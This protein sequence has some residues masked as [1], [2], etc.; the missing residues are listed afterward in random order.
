MACLRRILSSLYC[1]FNGR[2]GPSE[3]HRFQGLPVAILSHLPFDLRGFLACWNAPISEE[4]A[5]QY[6]VK[7]IGGMWARNWKE[8]NNRVDISLKVLII[9]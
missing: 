1:L 9:F 8:R 6:R 2:E 7:T 4:T 3:S 5:A